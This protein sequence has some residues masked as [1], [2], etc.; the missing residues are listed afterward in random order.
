MEDQFQL[1]CKFYIDQISLSILSELKV[2]FGPYETPVHQFP[3][4]CNLE[5]TD[6]RSSKGGKKAANHVHYAAQQSMQNYSLRHSISDEYDITTAREE[7]R[8][9]EREEPRERFHSVNKYP[10]N[11]FLHLAAIAYAMN[12]SG[13]GNAFTIS[14]HS[15]ICYLSFVYA[16]FQHS[17]S[18]ESRG[19]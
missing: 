14:I 12:P 3:W 6:T 10:H 2:V 19:R 5:I 4:S 13:E 9:V 17:Y 15:T 16:P 7:R 11:Y 8:E 1:S 18:K